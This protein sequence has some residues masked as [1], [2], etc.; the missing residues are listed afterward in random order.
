MRFAPG[1]SDEEL[2]KLILD[3]RP[4]F[5]H[6]FLNHL[7]GSNGTA[8]IIRNFDI[9]ITFRKNHTGRYEMLLRKIT[10]DTDT[11]MEVIESAIAKKPVIITPRFRNVAAA[12]NRLEQMG[13]YRV[14]HYGEKE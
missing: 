6:S 1:L 13:L 2:A 14:L 9:H 11:M 7:L 3:D 8:P 12:V 4:G 10:S 5:A